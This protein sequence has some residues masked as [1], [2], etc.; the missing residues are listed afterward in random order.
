M[1]IPARE[2]SDLIERPQLKRQ[3][4]D[5]TRQNAPRQR[6]DRLLKIRRSPERRADHADVQKYRC[7]CWNGKSFPD[8]HH[9]AGQRGQRNEQQVW[10]HDLQH[11]CCQ[12]RFTRRFVEAGR[13]Q[14]DQPR[15]SGNTQRGND[16][17]RNKLQGRHAIDE[18]V[19]GRF[20]ALA[21]VFC[22]QRHKRL[23]KRALGKQPTHH[24][25]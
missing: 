3:L 19:S 6:H 14:R 12:Q 10:K 5:A 9:A 18:L 22:D 20:A 13:E 17:Q 4:R 11:L 25:R 2:H 7:E 8:I 21:F 15:R 23:G 24:I 16:Q 1:K